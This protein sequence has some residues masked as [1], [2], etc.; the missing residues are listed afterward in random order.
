MWPMPLNESM[1]KKLTAVYQA[2]VAES[3]GVD[4]D[5]VNWFL[6]VDYGATRYAGPNEDP[7]CPVWTTV[8]WCRAYNTRNGRIL[9]RDRMTFDI[10]RHIH[11]W[12]FIIRKDNKK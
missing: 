12:V 4:L 10:H 1:M 2:Y 7:R 8:L 5:D 11:D 9:L 6:R 3:T